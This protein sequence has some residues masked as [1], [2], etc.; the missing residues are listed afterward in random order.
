M[1]FGKLIAIKKVS[2]GNNGIN[3]WICLCDCGNER[4]TS[5]EC[6]LRGK[7]RSCGCLYRESWDTRMTHGHAINKTTEYYAWSS[8][9]QRCYNEN[10]EEYPIYGGRGIKVCDR[11]RY[12]FENFLEDMGLK[13]SPD[14]SLDRWPD[15]NGNYEPG[16]CR[17]GT[18][19]EQGNNKST[20]RFYVLKE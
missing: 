11:W 13:P 17:W 6:L 19:L 4:I 16:N 5:I 7:T 14:L 10:K 18:T 9:K 2:K 1:R 20:N 3:K 15:M 8:M 12:S